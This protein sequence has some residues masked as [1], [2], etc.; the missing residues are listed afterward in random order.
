MSL[1][2]VL[3]MPKHVRIYNAATLKEE[4]LPLLEEMKDLGQR[5]VEKLLN[6]DVNEI[7]SVRWQL[8]QEGSITRNDGTVHGLRLVG[9]DMSPGC[10]ANLARIRNDP[11]KLAGMINSTRHSLHVYP[12]ASVGW[13]HMHSYVSDLLTSAHDSMEADAKEK[14]YRKNTPY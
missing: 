2:H 4:H 12:A 8:A 11:G 14:G 9:S 13:L 6:G 5:A 1:C 10:A 7:G 3:T